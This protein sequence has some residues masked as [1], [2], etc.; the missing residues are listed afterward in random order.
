MFIAFFTGCAKEQP[1]S[2][3]VV[4][5]PDGEWRAVADFFLQTGPGTGAEETIVRIERARGSGVD[6]TEVLAVQDGGD[7]LGLAMRWLTPRHLLIILKDD[8]KERYLYVPRAAGIEVS[9]RYES[10]DGRMR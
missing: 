8:P 10:P 9:L 6:S 3:T 2:S 5:S 1:V 7:T 4:R